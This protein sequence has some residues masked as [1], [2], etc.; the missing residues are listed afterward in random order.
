[1]KGYETFVSWVHHWPPCNGQGGFHEDASKRG[2]FLRKGRRG[3]SV[4]RDFPY[5]RKETFWV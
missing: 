3:E 5:R 1:M 2:S 4:I